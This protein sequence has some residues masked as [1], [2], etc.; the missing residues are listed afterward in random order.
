[1]NGWEISGSPPDISKLGKP[2]DDEHMTPWASYLEYERLESPG[3]TTSP[4]LYSFIDTEA[5]S[6]APVYYQ[7]QHVDYG[8]D[9]FTHNWVESSVMPLE[10]SLTI[11]E[12]MAD[13][14]TIIADN[15]GA[16]EDW[17]EI[18]NSSPMPVSVGGLFL[19]DDIN[20]PAK[21]A[22]PDTTIAPN[23]F[24]LI[25]CDSDPEDGPLHTNFKL[26]ASGEDIVLAGPTE[27][28]NQII[29]SYSFGPQST[30]ISEGRSFSGSPQWVF[31]SSPTP[32][33]PNL[34]IS[35]GL[36]DIS[37]PFILQPN[38]PNPFNPST[39]IK[40]HLESESIISIDIFDIDGQKIRSILNPQKLS[41]GIH[42]LNWNGCDDF[43]KK[44]ASGT[45]FVKASV[46]EMHQSLKISLIK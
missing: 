2:G 38:Y 36:P 7:L 37:H 6:N 40:F 39:T 32:G 35:G 46:G 5:P 12:F 13:N 21:W 8:G 41:S 11:N 23:G 29:S 31:F 25:W 42:H 18:T 34:E 28:G 9:T 22:F 24:L 1:M 16:Y 20:M 10:L 33:L 30:D 4:S 17:L 19:S 14:S 43:G 45:Y 26:S 44:A 15:T 27:F 3:E